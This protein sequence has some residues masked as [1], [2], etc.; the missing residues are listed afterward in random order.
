MVLV[1][2]CIGLV[3]AVILTWVYD[4]TPEGIQKTKSISEVKSGKKEKASIGWKISTYVSVVI[5]IA[6]VLFYVI[7]SDKKSSDVGIMEKSVAVLPFN[8]LSDDPEQEY[9]SNGLVEEILNRLCRISD[10]KVI[11]RTSSGRFKD[12][13]LSLKEIAGELGAAAIMEGSVQKSGN[14][15]R[16]AVQL[17]DAQT[18]THL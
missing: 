9:F 1:L 17:I 10:L 7:G 3:I 13:D 18:D 2:L 5:I 12:S 6:F 4:L 11:S 16:I 8:N 14:R 15:I